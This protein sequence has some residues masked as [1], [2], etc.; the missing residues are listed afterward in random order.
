METSHWHR[1]KVFIS[2]SHKD[3]EWLERLQVHLR[4]LERDGIIDRWDDTRIKPGAR[5]LEEMRKALR[6]ARVAVLLISADYLASDFIDENELPPLLEA[7]EKDALVVL[8]VIL[9]PSRFKYT[10]SLAQ[11]QPV[12]DPDRP[13]VEMRWGEQEKVLVKVTECITEALQPKDGDNGGGRVING[14]VDG[15][16]KWLKGGGVIAAVTVLAFIFFLMW[17]DPARREAATVPCGSVSPAVD[18]LSSDRAKT[19][20]S[21][22]NYPWGH[23]ADSRDT[24][25]HDF[26]VVSAWGHDGVSNNPEIRKQ[27][28]R[29]A[30]LGAK[31]LVWHL[32]ADGRAAPEFDEDGN[33]LGFDNFFYSDVDSALALAEEYQVAILFVLIDFN[34]FSAP[35]TTANGATLYGHAE[36]LRDS[37]SRQTFFSEALIPL[38]DRYCNHPQLSGWIII[39]EPDNAVREGLVSFPE[40]QAFIKEAAGHIHERA[41]RQPVTIGSADL[42]SLNAYLSDS[43]LGLDFLIFHQIGE[44]KNVLPPSVEYLQANLFEGNVPPLYIGEFPMK[45]GIMEVDDFLKWSWRL[46][47]SGAWPWSVND[48]DE[49]TARVHL[50]TTQTFYEETWN[51]LRSEPAWFDVDPTRLSPDEAEAYRADYRAWGAYVRQSRSNVERHLQDLASDS[52]RALDQMREDTLQIAQKDT[53]L[54]LQYR[55]LATQEAYLDSARTDSTENLRVLNEKKDEYA[56]VDSLINKFKQEKARYDSL[57]LADSLYWLEPA[58]E[59]LRTATDADQEALFRQKIEEARASIRQ[60]ERE[61]EK[62]RRWIPEKQGEL[63]AFLMEIEAYEGHLQASIEWKRRTEQEIKRIKDLIEGL[64]REKENARL[65]LIKNERWRDWLRRQIDFFTTIYAGF[66]AEQEQWIVQRFTAA[67]SP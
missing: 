30:A 13:L 36:T 24:Y 27:F 19:F 33:V 63:A 18:L 57:A 20:V 17:D 65:S 2:Y 51:R 23:D 6:E 41:P 56:R 4:P 7:E 10:E 32:F 39:N 47:Y 62:R 29:L 46:G 31:Q 55:D 59:G 53:L 48:P 1:T 54:Q 60:K 67:S 52:V 37:T 14:R 3:A 45:G 22:P 64:K 43:E 8:P 38:L 11:F 5:W 50:E 35:D 28:E 66:I 34:W 15:A 49:R 58:K 9:S 44:F 26:G 16:S 61:S 25:G 21:I 42:A 12:N 40:M